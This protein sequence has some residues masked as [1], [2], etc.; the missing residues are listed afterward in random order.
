MNEGMEGHP[1]AWVPSC[2]SGELGPGQQPHLPDLPFTH[3]SLDL[4]AEG[5]GMGGLVF[6]NFCPCP[7][8]PGKGGLNNKQLVPTDP[9]HAMFNPATH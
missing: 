2:C 4:G 7:Q 6:A 5:R 1:E 8:A 3:I 9:C